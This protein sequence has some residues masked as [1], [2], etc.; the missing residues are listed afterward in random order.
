MKKYLLATL[1]GSVLLTGVLSGCGSVSVPQ[2][3]KD[4]FSQKFPQAKN[5]S[6]ETENGNFEANWGGTSGEDNSVLY[7]PAANFLE[8]AKAIPP[9]DLPVPAITYI[10]TQYKDATIN[11]A[12]R[13]TDSSN[14][15]TYEAEVNHKDLVFD[16]DGNFTKTNKE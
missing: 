5:V 8:I 11:E 6:W 9:S 2:A 15:E 13:V 12:S 10:K 4:A 16:K 14:I 1:V 7:S 3:V